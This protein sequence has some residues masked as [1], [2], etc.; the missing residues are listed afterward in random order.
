MNRQFKKDDVILVTGGAGFLGSH[1]VEEL[2]QEDHAT[3]IIFDIFNE[4]TSSFTEKQKNIE[5]LRTKGEFIVVKGDITNKIDVRTVVNKYKPTLC[6]HAAALVM[7][8]RSVSEPTEFLMVNVVGTQ[9]LLEELRK[10]KYFEHFVLV[11]TR[12]ALGQRKLPDEE[13]LEDD[14]CRPINIYGASKGAAEQ[15][16]HAYHFVYGF[17]ANICR[18]N[19]MYGPRQRTDMLPYRILDSIVNEKSFNK[20]GTGNATRD[21]LYVQDGAKGI[22]KALKKRSINY[23]IFNFGT[24]VGTSLNNFIDTTNKIIKKPFHINFVDVPAGD[25][26]HGGICYSKKAKD[27]LGYNP[28]T[29]LED[30]IIKAYEYKTNTKIVD[31]RI[32]IGLAGTGIFAK[33]AHIH[34]ILQNKK[35]KLTAIFSRHKANAESIV[36]Y[37][38]QNNYNEQITI[39]DDMDEFFKSTL[40]EAVDIVLPPEILAEAVTLAIIGKKHILSEKPISHDVQSAEKTLYKSQKWMIAEGWRIEP[41]L[42]KARKHINDI[43]T[44]QIISAE[45][46][47]PVHEDSPYNESTWRKDTKGGLFADRGPH[48]FAA[49]RAVAGPMTIQSVHNFNNFE[50][51]FITIE[52]QS[53]AVGNLNISFNKRHTCDH[54]LK[55]VVLGSNGKIV[56]TNKHCTVLDNTGILI[57]DEIFNEF[58]AVDECISLFANSIKNNEENL[59]LAP[60]EALEDLRLV[61]SV[62]SI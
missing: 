55:I 37:I 6:V 8:R 53:G 3:I 56:V 40:F 51:L 11:S 23:E 45:C 19:P 58:K 2:L 13:I 22:I 4:E 32:K 44:I 9:I 31:D 17:T 39:Y 46:F 21:W 59:D 61:E 10:L 49:L 20:F 25:A 26:H 18:M 62:L 43:G 54:I 29:S 33:K 57:V 24:G 42:F 14:L 5:Y 48:I 52:F 30:G 36:E 1:I 38:K 47:W 34:G 50:H 60:I 16:L 12:S 27:I 7:D 15:V 35:F 28:E 41:S